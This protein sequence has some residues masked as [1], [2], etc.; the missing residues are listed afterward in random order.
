MEYDYKLIILNSFN[1]PLLAPKFS[2]RTYVS[3]KTHEQHPLAIKN[4]LGRE[5]IYLIFYIS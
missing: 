2:N 3:D 1:T 4:P 5:F